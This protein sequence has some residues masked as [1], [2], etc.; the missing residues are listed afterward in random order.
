MTCAY[1]MDHR[2]GDAALFRPFAKVMKDLLEN[3][4]NFKAENYPDSI[5]Y[6]E[7]AK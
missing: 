7:I 2:H 4:E 1:T 5:P 3:P 6:A